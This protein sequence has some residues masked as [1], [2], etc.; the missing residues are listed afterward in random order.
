[1]YYINRFSLIEA[2]LSQKS[3][4]LDY[5]KLLSTADRHQIMRR[6]EKTN[7]ASVQAGRF[8]I[9]EEPL[10]EENWS[11]MAKS[12][13]K[14]LN[15]LNENIKK[16]K[17]LDNAIEVLIS[18]KKRYPDVPAICNYLGIAFERTNQP[19]KYYNTLIETSER[20]PDYLFG[21]I[22]LAEYYLSKNRYRKIRDL[23]DNKFEITLH[24]PDGTDCFHISEVRGF[25]YLD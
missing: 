7:P 25:Y 23:L 12:D 1:M 14:K 20:F 8:F 10:E 18:Y 6:I 13:K 19:K 22:S 9:T 4:Y 2:M 5:K 16:L 24:Y 11:K 21:K 15:R 17:N 3:G